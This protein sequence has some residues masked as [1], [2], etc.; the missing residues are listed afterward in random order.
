VRWKVDEVR[1]VVVKIDKGGKVVIK[2]AQ[3]STNGC[4]RA[5]GGG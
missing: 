5:E 2:G 3:V 1:E 4:D